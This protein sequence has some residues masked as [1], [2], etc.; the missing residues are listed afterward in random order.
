[1]AER[2]DDTIA[3]LR[4]VPVFSTLSEDELAHVKQVAMPRRFDAGAV[5]FKEGDEGS[6]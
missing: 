6:T 4:C 3:L 5:V 1:M 2:S